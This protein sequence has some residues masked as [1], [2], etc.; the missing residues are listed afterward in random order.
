MKGTIQLCTRLGASY[1]QAHEAE[2]N[3]FV[4]SYL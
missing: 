2:P 1:D 3:V 4:T